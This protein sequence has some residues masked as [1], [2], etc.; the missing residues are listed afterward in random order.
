MIPIFY[1]NIGGLRRSVPS[2]HRG[3]P[4]GLPRRTECRAAWWEQSS[5]RSLAGPAVVTNAVQF[6]EPLKKR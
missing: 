2:D 4:A 1:A 5:D 6:P 3:R